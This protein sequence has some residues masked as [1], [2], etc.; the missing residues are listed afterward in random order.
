MLGVGHE[1]EDVAALV[2]DARDV[3]DGAVRV[4]ARLVPEQDLTGRVELGDRLGVGEPAAVA[5][6]HGDRE[7]L[8]LGAAGGERAVGARD[9]EPDVAADERERLVLAERARK[10]PASVR[11]WKPLQIP[12]T[13]P[14]SP[15]NS[16]DRLHDRREAG[17]RAA[18]EVVAVREPAREDDACGAGRKLR[19][20]VPDARRRPRRGASG[21]ARRRGRRSSPGRRRRRSGAGA[22]RRRPSR[23]VQLDLVALDQRVREQLLAHP[24]DLGAGLAL[25]VDR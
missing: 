21:R 17:D 2:A 6:L 5:V 14:P 16:V 4:L 7:R 19:V 23:G 25:V 8:A 24:L 13:R 20:V 15:A 22:L 3:G 9:L 18:A 1:A 11:I 12:S 10:Q